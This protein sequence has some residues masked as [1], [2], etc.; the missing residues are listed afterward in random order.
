MG[1]G[2]GPAA[3]LPLPSHREVPGRSQESVSVGFLLTVWFENE[4][5]Q[6]DIRF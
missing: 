6:T 5:K 1:R 2:T 3:A 4:K